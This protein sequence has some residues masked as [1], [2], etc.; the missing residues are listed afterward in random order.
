MRFDKA[1]LK[2]VLSDVEALGEIPDVDLGFS[3]DSR[4][5]S[6]NEVFIA[7]EGQKA[8]GHDFLNQALNSG[9]SGFLIKISE[10]ERLSFLNSEELN[11]KFVIL[12]SD[13]FDAVL[14]LAKFWREKFEYP[15]VGITGSVGK[16][17][18][19][20]ILANICRA[21]GKNVLVSKGN[22]NTLLGVALNILK[23]N[24][25][26][27][28]AIF[29]V[30]INKRG[31]MAQII[32]L[33]RPTLGVITSVGHSHME[34]LGSLADVTFEKRNIFRLFKEDH[35][36]IINGDADHLSKIGYAHPVVRFGCKTT[37]QIQAR[38]IKVSS[39]GIDFFLKI[40]KKKF[41]V[42][43]ETIHAGYIYN[44]LAASAAACVLGIP[45]EKIIEG[46]SKPLKIVGR[47]E[48]KELA[49]GQGFLIDDC[50]N[51]NPESVKE[52]LLAF[53]R[54]QTDY[55]KVV[56]LSDMNELGVDSAFWHRQIGRFLRKINSLHKVILVGNKI[57]WVKKTLPPG[58]KALCYNHWEEAKN[59]IDQLMNTQKLC[60][61]VKGSTFGY[62]SGLSDLVRSLTDSK[63]KSSIQNKLQEQ[64]NT[65]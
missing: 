27:S 16:T 33:L 6:E 40:Y 3:V 21:S 61:L 51:A 31:E 49:S 63:F 55:E 52:A 30:G 8:D 42:H 11:K 5:V 36:G 12:V 59:D 23:M 7:L 1:L 41:P 2:S 53:E 19:K 29:E 58:V 24:E 50:Y 64:R 54:I 25:E 62:T 37:N 60:I 13:T 4:T 48:K 32:D 43:L 18:T 14:S 22:Q 57:K 9:A 35:I 44:T 39:F 26:H 56:V 47:F 28:A 34:G 15:V 10:K 65:I 45:E 46:I 38:K 20:E 17:S